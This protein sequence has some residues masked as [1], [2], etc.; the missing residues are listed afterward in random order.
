M[1]YEKRIECMFTASGLAFFD[2]R[3]W[4]ELT[5]GTPIHFPVPAKELNILRLPVYTF[6]GSGE[7]SAPLN[8]TKKY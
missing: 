3:G 8:S 1:K 2:D 7:G 5:P 4:G 6:G